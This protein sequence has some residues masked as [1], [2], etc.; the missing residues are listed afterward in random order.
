[1]CAYVC[2]H[3]KSPEIGLRAHSSALVGL[4]LGETRSTRDDSGCNG[5]HFNNA[6]PTIIRNRAPYRGD[7]RPTIAPRNPAS[8]QKDRT[9]KRFYDS[10][11]DPNRRPGRFNKGD[12]AHQSCEF[13]CAASSSVSSFRE[14]CVPRW[15]PEYVHLVWRNI[16][17]YLCHCDLFFFIFIFSY[18][19]GRSLA[20][21]GTSVA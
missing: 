5:G 6:E 1:M 14:I 21:N 13:L 12:D 9:S 18:Y 3:G 10:V 16:D 15:R 8:V 7:G 4:A 2:R 19:L 20:L 17:F 11:P